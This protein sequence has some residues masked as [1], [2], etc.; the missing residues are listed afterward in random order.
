MLGQKPPPPFAIMT[1]AAATRLSQ[2][3]DIG[4]LKQAFGKIDENSCPRRYNFHMHTIA[5]DGKLTP[6]ALMTQ[7]VEIGL[8]GMAITDHH[9][10]GGFIKA[11]EWLDKFDAPNLHLWTGIEVTAY[12]DNIDVHILGYG[13][14]PEAKELSPYLT[15]REP[16]GVDARVDRTVAAIHAAGGLAILAHPARY[17]RK[18]ETIVPMAI[19]MG[20]DGLEAYYAYKNP[21]PWVPSY[22]ET[23]QIQAFAKE[24]NIYTTC[25]TDTHGLNLLQRL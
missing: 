17:R 11:I 19:A 1:V 14:N 25:G 23:T 22:P 16:R 12:I 9:S 3:R 2:A 8:Q 21:F 7:A 13:F 20:I 18:P 24:S 15:G 6:E 10:I 5:S 4:A